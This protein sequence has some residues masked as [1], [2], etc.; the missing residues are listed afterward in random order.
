VKLID[1]KDYPALLISNTTITL[2]S[3]P[4]GFDL[5]LGFFAC[6]F[7][8]IIKRHKKRYGYNGNSFVCA[9]EF[10]PK[11]KKQ[12]HCLVEVTVAIQNQNT[13]TIKHH[14]SKRKFKDVL[15][16]KED[17]QNGAQLPSRRII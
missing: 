6:F 13:L 2:Q 7:T 10:G 4:I 16:Y 5:H 14:V 8:S 11:I 9:V 17:V 3:S 12:S 1:F 15:F